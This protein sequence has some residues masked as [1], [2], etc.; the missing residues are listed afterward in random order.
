MHS[1]G[2]GFL[3]T[4]TNAKHVHAVAGERQKL[5]DS[6]GSGRFSLGLIVDAVDE[7]A[8]RGALRPAST[9]FRIFATI[10]K[11]GSTTFATSYSSACPISSD[12]PRSDKP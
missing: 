3:L 4:T 2:A 7:Q 9:D 5:L 1:K 6:L 8:H 11:C 10:V 12:A